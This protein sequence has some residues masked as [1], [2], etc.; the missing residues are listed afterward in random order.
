MTESPLLKGR[1]ASLDVLR[2][3]TMVLLTL[4]SCLLF[5]KLRPAF[6]GTWAEGILN[7]FFHHP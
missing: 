7:Q 6:S 4:E 3:I 2:G 1:L 5:D